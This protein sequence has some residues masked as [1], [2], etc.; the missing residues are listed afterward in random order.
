MLQTDCLFAVQTSVRYGSSLAWGHRTVQ[1]CACIAGAWPSVQGAPRSL[2][3]PA[4]P[5]CCVGKWGA[6]IAHAMECSAEE[7]LLASSSCQMSV[8]YSTRRLLCIGLPIVYNANLI[9]RQRI[10]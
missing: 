9:Q 3:A 1:C 8:H 6:R 2:Q 5:N 7:C 10:R 4:G